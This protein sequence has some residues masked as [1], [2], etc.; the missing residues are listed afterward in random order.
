MAQTQSVLDSLCNATCCCRGVSYFLSVMQHR[1][2][3]KLPKW[4]ECDLCCAMMYSHCDDNTTSPNVTCLVLLNLQLDQQRDSRGHTLDHTHVHMLHSLLQSS[5]HCFSLMVH[6]HMRSPTTA[7]KGSLIYGMIYKRYI[8]VAINILL[9][10]N[11]V[12]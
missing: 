2:Q 4:R 6:K 10:I 7:H 9:A 1:R 3:S 5:C 12:I 11:R 8:Y